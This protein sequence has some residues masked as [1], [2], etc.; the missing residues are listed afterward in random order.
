M[1]I[2][3]NL[4][5]EKIVLGNKLDD[6]AISLKKLANTLLRSEVSSYLIEP[7]IINRIL[8]IADRISQLKSLEENEGEIFASSLKDMVDII[9][10][11]GDISRSPQRPSYEEKNKIIRTFKNLAEEIMDFIPVIRNLDYE[12]EKIKYETF[13]G[14]LQKLV[15]A[16]Q[17]KRHMF[18]QEDSK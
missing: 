15:D 13:G 18:I 1:F 17:E 8:K 3:V 5:Q 7:Q 12:G 2:I 11:I 4:D 9:Q 6:L 16:I 10:S 14:L